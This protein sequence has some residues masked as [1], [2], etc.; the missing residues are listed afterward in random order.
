MTLTFKNEGSTKV[1][2][3][4]IFKISDGNTTVKEFIHDFA[5]LAPG[6]SQEFP[7]QWDTSNAKKDVIYKVI[8]YVSYSSRATLPTFEIISTNTPPSAG[9]TLHS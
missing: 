7:D 2:G 4:C 8:G 6:T 3:S 1:S 5:D 9:F